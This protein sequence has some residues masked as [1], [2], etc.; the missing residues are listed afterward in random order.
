MAA[1]AGV[2]VVAIA[3]RIAPDVE[4]PVP[5]YTLEDA[6]GLDAAMAD[7]LGSAAYVTRAVLSQ[8]LSR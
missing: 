4:A 1:E 7:P 8:A 6:V 5:V 3:G 2:P